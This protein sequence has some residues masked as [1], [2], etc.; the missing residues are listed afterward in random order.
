MEMGEIAGTM[1][2]YRRGDRVVDDALGYGT[3]L[4]EMSG[5]LVPVV[6]DD[7]IAPRRNVPWWVLTKAQNDQL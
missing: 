2:I 5:Y 7:D 1:S 3:V 4:D 6:F